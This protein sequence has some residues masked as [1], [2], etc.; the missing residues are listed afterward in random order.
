MCVCVRACVRA[1]VCVVMAYIVM[2]YRVMACI[3]M[4]CIVMAERTLDAQSG[5][6]LVD[7][8]LPVVRDYEAKIYI[9]PE[10]G[11]RIYF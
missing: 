3:V 6:A 5:A 10:V 8:S 1:F 2:A 9:K 4:A 11:V 7:N